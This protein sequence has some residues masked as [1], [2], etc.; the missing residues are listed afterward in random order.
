MVLIVRGFFEKFI[1]ISEPLALAKEARPGGLQS[2]VCRGVS[3]SLRYIRGVP[4]KG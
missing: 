1:S 2:R 4:K 3:G